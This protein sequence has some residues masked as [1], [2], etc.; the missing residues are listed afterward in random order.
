MKQTHAKTAE[1]PIKW[2]MD[3]ENVVHMHM[4]F[5]SFV[6]KYEI[7][8]KMDGTGRNYTELGNPCPKR[9]MPH[10]IFHMWTL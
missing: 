8:S 2:R 6:K 3:N 5:Y 4:E 7:F 1:M 10:V 9:Q